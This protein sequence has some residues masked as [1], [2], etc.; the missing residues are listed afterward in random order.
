MYW[1]I[2]Y[3]KIQRVAD[4]SCYYYITTYAL[5]HST[6]LQNKNFCPF[7]GWSTI[8]CFFGWSIFIHSFVKCWRY[9]WKKCKVQFLN[10]FDSTTIPSYTTTSVFLYYNIQ[11][12]Y[13]Q[14]FDLVYAG[15]NHNLFTRLELCIE[16]LS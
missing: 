1:K 4:W 14:V 12:I 6:I 15:S 2:H 7:L 8:S 3:S 13:N 9:E 11:F 16:H 5:M 10:I